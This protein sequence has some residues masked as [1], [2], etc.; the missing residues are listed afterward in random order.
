[1]TPEELARVAVLRYRVWYEGVF[2]PSAP[3]FERYPTLAAFRADGLDAVAAA[4]EARAAELRRALA[5]PARRA[6]AVATL[7]AARAG[8]QAIDQ[9]VKPYVYVDLVDL[10]ARLGGDAAIADALSGATV[11]EY[12]GAARPGAHGV[13]I[14]LFDRPAADTWGTYDPNY[15]NYVPATGAGNA[16]EFITRFHWDELL[17]EFY[18]AQGL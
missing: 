11:A 13:S 9:H 10:E 8:A 16:S 3:A 14:V 1:M 12:H 6:D 5:D 4:V 2:F 15:R 18:A 7:S 17:A